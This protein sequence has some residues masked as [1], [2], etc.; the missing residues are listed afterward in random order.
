MKELCS[1]GCGKEAKI[2]FKNG[3]W[4]CSRSYQK[5]LYWKQKQKEKFLTNNPMSGRNAWNKDLTKETDERVLNYSSK[6]KGQKR[7]FSNEV[8][9][10]ISNANTKRGQTKEAKEKQKHKMLNGGAAHANSF[11]RK[12]YKNNK[13]WM[14]NGGSSYIRK[15]IKNPSKEELKL[16]IMVKELYPTSEHTYKILNYDVDIALMEHKIAIEFDGY[17]HFDTEEHKEYHKRRQEEIKEENWKFLRY[18]IFQPFPTLEQVKEDINK[19]L[20]GE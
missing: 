4:C 10:N 1:Y 15:C 11:P 9:K 19:I 6:Q 2:Q 16:R 7:F 20:N 17:F 14:K 8:I 3:R 13:E 12:G 18:N 5:C